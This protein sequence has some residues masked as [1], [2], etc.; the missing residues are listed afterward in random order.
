[1]TNQ[2]TASIEIDG[3]TRNTLRDYKIALKISRFHC[4]ANAKIGRKI[5]QKNVQ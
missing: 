1:M 5:S 2:V 3:K 4:S